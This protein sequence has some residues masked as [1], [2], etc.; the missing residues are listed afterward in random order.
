[1]N[2]LRKNSFSRFVIIFL[3]IFSFCYLVSL[4]VIG[5]SAPGNYYS[6]FIDHYLNFIS[7]IRVSLLFGTKMI[8]KIFGVETYYAG[9]YVLRKVNGRG[10]RL[11]YSCIGYG[12]MSFW[13]AFIT[14]SS[15]E[16]IKKLKWVAGGLLLIWFIN[17]TRMALLLIA[18][19][20]NWQMPFGW[21][22]H[23]WFNIVAYAAIFL[24]IYFFERSS[25]TQHKI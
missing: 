20:N 11:V 15:K 23:T 22:H 24:M 17:I 2:L 16:W 13:I 6:A 8:L 14:A 21:D 5:V 1:M 10:I 25:D 3:L 7:W 19:N 4:A 9:E 18:T 12:I